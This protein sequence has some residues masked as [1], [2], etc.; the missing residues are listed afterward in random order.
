MDMS[1]WLLKARFPAGAVTG[2]L[3]PCAVGAHGSLPDSDL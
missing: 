3:G 1:K 2:A